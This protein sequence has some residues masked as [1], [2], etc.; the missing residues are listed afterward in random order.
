MRQL[1]GFFPGG[2]GD[3][4]NPDEIANSG[5][6]AS[7]ASGTFGGASAKSS[8]TKLPKPDI[9]PVLKERAE[10]DRSNSG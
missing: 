7:V 9:K 6:F 3:A 1:N 2:S 5:A 10:E 4:E 8:A